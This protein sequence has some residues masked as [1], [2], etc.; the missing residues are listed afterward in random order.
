MRTNKMR[1]IVVVALATTAL[2]GSQAM[3]VP[4]YTGSLA[5]DYNSGNS[6]GADGLILGNDGWVTSMPGPK[7]SVVVGVKSFSVSYGSFG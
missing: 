1:M 6:T 2:W 4:T 5:S 7:A 3:A